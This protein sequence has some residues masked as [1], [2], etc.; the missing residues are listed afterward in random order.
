MKRRKI[1]G[2]ES[3]SVEHRNRKRIAHGHRGRSRGRRRKIKRARFFLHTDVEHNIACRRNC[4][5][6]MARQCHHAQSQAL[7]RFQQRNNFFRF[8]AITHREHNVIAHQHAQIAV[9]RF[10]RMQKRSR[11]TGARKCR[12]DFSAD[13]S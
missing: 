6:R 8:A 12:G 4:R 1:A 11:R 5:A 2:T 13:Q 10:G 9:N 3:S 7:D